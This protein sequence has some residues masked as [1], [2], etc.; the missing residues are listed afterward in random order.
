MKKTFTFKMSTGLKREKLL[1]VPVS[2]PGKENGKVIDYNPQTGETKIEVDSSFELPSSPI[3]VSSRVI[4][5]GREKRLEVIKVQL[6]VLSDEDRLELFSN[7]CKH[8][9]TKNLGCQC[10][11]DE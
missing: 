1:L 2:F 4:E 9:G 11:N 3:L 10:W 7:Y 6:D 8:C 5:N